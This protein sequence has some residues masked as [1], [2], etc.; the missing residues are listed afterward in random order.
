MSYNLTGAVQGGNFTLSR[1]GGATANITGLS[2]AASTYTIQ[3]VTFSNQGKIYFKATAAGAATPTTN[4]S[5]ISATQAN[6]ASGA[7]FVA[8]VAQQAL[9][10]STVALAGS[11]C[12]YVFGLDPAGNVRV[13][14]GPIVNYTDTSANS[15]RCPLP[16][17]PDWMTPVAYAVI[18]LV[19]ATPATWLFGTG[20][21]NAAGVTIDTPVDVAALPA[22]D[23]LTA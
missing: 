14:Q 10:G 1:A 11:A 9:A 3:N 21:W 13:S 2:G 8:Q 23:P 7:A 12:A 6:A 19:S 18:K 20:L 4:A 15:T 5:S 22:N 17:L 16:S